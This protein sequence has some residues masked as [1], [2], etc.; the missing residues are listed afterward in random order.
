MPVRRNIRIMNAVSLLQGMVFY[1]SVA[2][3]YRQQAGLGVF[4]IALIESISLA[5]SMLMELPWG[6]VSDRIGYRKSMIIVNGL[7][8]VSK[9]VFWQ[10]DGFGMFLLERILLAAV[11]SG[12]SGLD[13]SVLY[14]SCEP[15]EAQSVFGAYENFGTAGMLL[16]AGLFSLFMENDY[17]LAALLT[18]ATH[19]AAFALTLGLKEVRQPRQERETAARSFANALKETLGSKRLLM[20]VL[21]AALLGEAHQTITVFLNQLKYEQCGIPENAIALIYIGVNLLSLLGGLSARLTKRFGAQRLGVI[22]YA[23]SA[24]AC[25]WLSFTRSAAASVL[26]IALLRVSFSL[27]GPLWS[28]MKNRSIASADRATVLS[29]GATLGSGAAIAANL[30]FGRLADMNLALAMF[31]GAVL[32]AAGLVLFLKSRS[33]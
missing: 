4:E 21:S 30:G 11:I 19:A 23:A 31:F 28:D 13:E 32:C 29:A 9:I 6:M 10:A 26:C 18:A 2:T 3:L 1:A 7:F 33:V 24:A 20:I 5:L 15:D 14:C 16:S 25:L 22:L 27:L 8:F 12:L 17:R